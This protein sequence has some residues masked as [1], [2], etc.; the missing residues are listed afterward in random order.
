MLANQ[1]LRA[2][3]RGQ[4]QGKWTN[5]VVVT[6]IFLVIF[7]LVSYIPVVGSGL[8]L[9]LSGPF[10]LGISQYFLNF[11]R[12]NNPKIEDLF[13]GFNHLGSSIALYFVTVIFI[14]LWSLLLIIPGIVAGIR[15]SMAFYV[16]CDHPDMGAMNALNTSK[17]L[18]KENKMQL[19]LLGL[20]FW[21]WAVCCVFTFG[22]GF[23]WL[24]PYV[25][26]SIV[27]FYEEARTAQAGSL[28]AEVVAKG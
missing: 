28:P 9:I 27:N 15:Y 7:I 23:L 21:G 17:D 10:Y 24:I 18:M 14:L 11:K 12:G 6:L 1:E 3:A 25:T 22:I 26:L 4:L 8:T 19:L 13:S 2:R 5:P 20:S 16:L